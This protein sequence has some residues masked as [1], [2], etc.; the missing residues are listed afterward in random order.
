[1]TKKNRK[2]EFNYDV[3]LSFAGEDRE[4]IEE[5]A[6]YLVE[7]GVRV[8]YD[9]YE[10]VDLW[11][12]DLYTHFDEIYRN[13]ARYCVLFISRYYAEKVWTNH[14]R[15]SAQ[16]RA[17]EENKE[18]I[19]P[20]R[21]DD[22]EI[23]GL[24]DTIGYI[25]IAERTP[26]DLAKLII[27]KLG[28]H[29]KENY[30]PPVPDKLFGILQI[31]DDEELK[32]L[33]YRQAYDFLS[34]LKRMSNEERKVIFIT[35][36]SGCPAELPDNIHIDS[37][38]LRRFTGYPITKLKRLLGGISSLGFECSMRENADEHSGLHSKA[39]LFVIEWHSRNIEFGGN[40]TDLAS[41]MI[42]GGASGYCEEH[43][44]MA[45]E[46]LDFSQLAAVTTVEDY[47]ETET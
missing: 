24:R 29:E 30:L 10:V 5:I 17:I 23:P 19:L 31:E 41:A 6:A 33:A 4:Y 40:L 15:Q 2:R 7:N 9:K 35:F 34:V 8:F 13:A 32:S 25:N 36:L 39:K 44:L 3:C 14:E 38:L 42:M 20:V 27:E 12:K 11:G 46:R 16:A 28:K 22:S 21:F 43:G 1:M 37:D 18:Y 45:L 26:T 47:H